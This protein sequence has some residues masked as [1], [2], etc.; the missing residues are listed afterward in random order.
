MRR[1][2]KSAFNS[3]KAALYLLG[4][5]GLIWFGTIVL[6]NLAPDPPAVL[7]GRQRR[8]LFKDGAISKAEFH[9][10]ALL[11][12]R[13]ARE[14]REEEERLAK[15]ADQSAKVFEQ[16]RR[17]DEV[18]A[19]ATEDEKKRMDWEIEGHRGKG[20]SE[21]VRDEIVREGERKGRW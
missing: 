4:V 12:E 8:R 2:A 5:P 18:R 15:E 3:K 10:P 20:M 14:R 16:A 1:T 6:L 17:W 9:S 19:K 21:E 13:R 11:A 7:E